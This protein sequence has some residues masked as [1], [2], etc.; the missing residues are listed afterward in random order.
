[1]TA[2]LGSRFA[3]LVVALCLAR[4]VGADAAPKAD[5]G[6]S[7]RLSKEARTARKQLGQNYRLARTIAASSSPARILGHATEGATQEARVSNL[8]AKLDPAGARDD[9]ARGKTRLTPRAVGLFEAAAQKLGQAVEGTKAKAREEKAALRRPQARLTRAEMAECENAL[10]RI[11]HLSANPWSR[12]ISFFDGK[13]NAVG[14][15]GV[16]NMLRRGETV[17]AQ[18]GGYGESVYIQRGGTAWTN[19]QRHG[20]ADELR[21]LQDFR[22]WM[23]SAVTFMNG[24]QDTR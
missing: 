5:P 7:V 18:M 16:L 14:T 1:M 10:A 13:G 6:T 22:S 9:A 21:S 8:A 20:G 12:W 23:K 15:G 17:Q 2:H 24:G 19:P 4:A 3:G 11:N